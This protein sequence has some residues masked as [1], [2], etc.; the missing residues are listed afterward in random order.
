MGTRAARLDDETERV[1]AEIVMATGL[2][3]SAAMKKGLLV[4]RKEVVQEAGVCRT[5]STGSSIS[6]RGATPWPPRPR[7]GGVFAWPFAASFG[8]SWPPRRVG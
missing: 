4:L 6:G 7:H 2:S 3:I 8:S 5:T 1:L